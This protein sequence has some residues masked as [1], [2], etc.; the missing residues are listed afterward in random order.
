MPRDAPDIAAAFGL[1]RPLGALRPLGNGGHPSA[2]GVLT[3]ERG[4]WVVKT[5]RLIGDWQRHQ[6][7]RAHRLETGALAAGI[8]IPR[9]VEPPSPAVGHWY[10]PGG[11][12]LVRVTEWVEGHD[13]RGPGMGS[14]AD[15]ADAARWVGATLGRVALL[16][17]GAVGADP[18]SPDSVSPRPADDGR[19][20]LHPMADWRTWVAEAEAGD[21]PVAR[22]ARS[23]LPVIEEATV[24]IERAERDRPPVVPVHGDTS[25]ANVLRTPGGYVL[26]D[27][28]SAG[29]EVPWWETV[30]VAFRFATDF[31]GPTAEAD[32]R[33]VRPLIESYLEQGAPGGATDVSAFAGMLRS[34]L[35]SVAWCLWLALG[36]RGADA[37]Q[38]AFGLGLV[39]S[40]E[41]QLPRVLRS[42][43]A[44]TA[45]LR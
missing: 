19:S 15:L 34:Q 41:R 3:T 4:R 27:W 26:I 23:L 21:G 17:S 16:G 37:S 40:A 18:V 12:D 38:R 14:A 39:T 11:Q 43:D 8:G 20:A 29:A 33:V 30:G 9:P 35:A 13:L 24:L 6:A 10:H 45:L 32:A 28:D 25:R 5:G 44:W 42:L 2:T 31:N 22:P 36:H 7:V 1:G